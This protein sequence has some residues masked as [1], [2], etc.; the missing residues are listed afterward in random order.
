[1]TEKI[2]EYNVNGA[3][4]IGVD[5]GYGNMKT[6]RRCFKTALVKYDSEPVLSREHLEYEGKFYVIGEGHKGFVADKQSDEDNYILTL[7]AIAKELEA[8]GMK[9]AVNTARVHLAVGLPLKWVQAQKEDFRKYLMRN[10][11]VEVRYKNR[12]YRLE[13]VGCTV[14][15]QCYS[16]VAEN[17]KEFK[18]I[19]LLADIGNGTMNLMYLNNGRP[20]ESKSW[21]E[22]LGV[23][24]CYQKIHNLIQDNTGDCLM[25]EVVESFLRTGETDLPEKYAK[26]MKQ[27]AT[28]YTELVMQ[29]LRDHEFNEELMRVYFMGGGAKLVEQFGKYNPER[30]IFNHDIRANAKGY[31]YYCYMLLRHQNQRK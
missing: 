3:M 23:F 17:L 14:M 30:T 2:R 24:Q 8:R 25:A 26:L 4:I 20:M 5:N 13:F 16:A 19:T 15:P 9:D 1:M 31:E 12:L 10:H 18:G 6:A 28:E 21:T 29:K 27:G 7:A 22:K 11:L